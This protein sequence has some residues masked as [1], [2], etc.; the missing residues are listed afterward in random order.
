MI[1]AQVGPVEY[2][3]NKVFTVPYLPILSPEALWCNEALTD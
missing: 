3:A 2:R 1:P